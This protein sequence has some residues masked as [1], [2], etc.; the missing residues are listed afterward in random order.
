MN[1][2]R[3]LSRCDPT[4]ITGRKEVA[5]TLVFAVEARGVGGQEPFHTPTRLPRGVSMTRAATGFPFSHCLVH[6]PRFLILIRNCFL[7][8]APY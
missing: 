8:A 4:A 2:Q 7:G 1:D 5:K 6:R 3:Q